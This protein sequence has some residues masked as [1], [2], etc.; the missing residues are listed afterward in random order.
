MSGVP[1][2]MS[3]YAIAAP[4]NGSAMR[5]GRPRMMRRTGQAED[6]RLR[7]DHQ[8][9]K[10]GAV[11]EAVHRVCISVDTCVERGVENLWINAKG[12]GTSVQITGHTTPW[13]S[14]GQES[15]RRV[16]A[17]YCPGRVGFRPCFPSVT[18]W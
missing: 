9:H 17:G 5:P 7:D 1:R 10:G 11:H 14:C 4:R 2:K 6:Q 3:A 18:A 13:N 8:L 15:L 12:F 16:G